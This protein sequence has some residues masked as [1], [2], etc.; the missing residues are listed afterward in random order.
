MVKWHDLIFLY[1]LR[2]RSGGLPKTK[3]IWM[4]FQMVS[5]AIYDFYFESTTPDL[6]NVFDGTM[7]SNGDVVD[8]GL[9]QS[10]TRR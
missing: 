1:F 7:L 8:D 9:D 3:L 6:L 2:V 10:L 4:M 5:W